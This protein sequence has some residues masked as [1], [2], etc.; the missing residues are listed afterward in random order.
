MQDGSFTNTGAGTNYDNTPQWVK[1]DLGRVVVVT[2]V[3]IGTATNNIPGGWSRAFTSFLPV[4]Y[5]LDNVTW[6][7]AFTTPNFTEDGIYTFNTSFSARYV[8]I[9][10]SGSYAALS[11]FYVFAT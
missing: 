3:V 4:Q 5:S 2:G 7:T 11:E 9:F 10:S 1:M 6:T 8:R